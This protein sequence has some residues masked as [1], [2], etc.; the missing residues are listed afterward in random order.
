MSAR[1]LIVLTTLAL[2]VALPAAAQAKLPAPKTKKIVFGTSI[3]GVRLG[4]SLDAAKAAWGPGQEC[5][6]SSGATVT[7][8]R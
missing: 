3:A 6:E 2:A 4:M 8:T 7:T 1:R 5:A